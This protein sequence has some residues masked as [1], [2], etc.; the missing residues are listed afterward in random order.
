ML[1]NMV[2]VRQDQCDGY[3]AYPS[4]ARQHPKPIQL[5]GCWTHVRRKFHEAREQ[6]PRVTGW[7]L[8]QIQLLYQV[9]AALR[10]KK[11]GPKLRAAVRAG[12]SR[13]VVERLH[14]ALL[15][16]RHRQLPKSLLGQAIDYALGQ[17]PTLGVCLGDGRVEIDNQ[18]VP[19]PNER[20]TRWPSARTAIRPTAV[21]K[22]NW[23]FMGEDLTGWLEY[24]AEGL[25]QTL[26][27]VWLRVQTYSG[28]NKGKLVLRPKQEQLL[29]LLR[30]HGSMA[31]TE[32]WDALGV[33]KQGAMDLLRPLLEA[34]LVEKVGSKKTGR[35]ALQK[36]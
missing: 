21:G 18:A 23:L 29:K 7:F 19:G 4:F 33:S 13:W 9:E 34:G 15:R 1:L 17:W 6:T 27:R 14:R 28:E 11:A 10:E 12:T 26:E 36:Q 35:Y 8:R 30:D 24:S 20:G 32:I 3:A 5:A 16:H 2:A 25:Q 22:K 31:P